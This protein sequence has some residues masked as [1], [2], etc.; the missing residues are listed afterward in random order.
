MM[1]PSSQTL[2]IPEPPRAIPK[3]FY[4]RRMRAMFFCGV[5]FTALGAGLAV[6][7]S[8]FFWV[9]SGHTWP[10]DDLALNRTH[11]SATATITEKECIRHINVG[12][13]HPWKVSFRFTDAEDRTVEAVGFT[14]D[15][16]FGNKVPGDMMEVEYDPAEPTRARP[17]GGS[18][19]VLPLWAYL[20]G[21][22]LMGPDLVVG[23]VLLFLVRL[24][25]RGERILL[26]YGAGAEA[27]VA[28]VK[29]LRHIRFGTRNPYDVYYE[30]T[31]HLG[32]RVAGRDRTY[33]YA[34]AEALTPG[35]R[36]GVVYNPQAPAA[37]VLWL[38]GVDSADEGPHGA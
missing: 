21:L 11:A 20:L 27:E 19:A 37:N 18:A 33:H 15:Q 4:L 29:R 31:D 13:T 9:L 7:L 2:I 3:W 22:A 14:Y 1:D 10:T 17:V 24:R 12:S 32:R 30:F 35:D 36:V 28:R 26:V 38:H 16:S 8:V 23:V 25:A 5:L 6:G 34:W